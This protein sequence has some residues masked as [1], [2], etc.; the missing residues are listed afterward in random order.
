MTSLRAVLFLAVKDLFQDKRILAL[1]IFVL[2]LSFVN[3]VFFSSFINGLGE[4]MQDEIINTASGHVVIEPP[5]DEP[6]KYLDFEDS[7]RKKVNALPEVMGSSSRLLVPGTI[8]FEEREVS[9]PII[10]ID[11]RDERSVTWIHEEILMGEF[12]SEN[13]RNE[14]ILGKDLAGFE[15]EKFFIRKRG[16]DVDVGE[17]VHVSFGNGVER[18]FH[19]KAIAGK[20]FGDVTRNAYISFEEAEEIANV[21]GKASQVLVKLSDKSLADRYKTLIAEQ[22]IKDAEIKTWREYLAIADVIKDTYGV[23]VLI[24]TF[25]GILVAFTTIGVVTYISAQRKKRI[26]AVLRATGCSKSFIVQVFLVQSFIFAV[27][28]IS[29]GLLI[30]Q[31]IIYYLDLYP[32]VTG[33]GPVTPILTGDVLISSVVTLFIAIIVAAVFPAWKA[34]REDILQQMRAQ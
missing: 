27:I 20:A 33:I 22:A 8:V 26:I 16:L 34:S 9:A 7:I 24:M 30:S 25:V 28:G 1:V 12:L 32:V 17:T 11:P 21:S 23:V 14:I 18:D 6:M 29:A 10:G 3:V 4:T 5:I 2:A 31:L 19:V 13:D 15:K